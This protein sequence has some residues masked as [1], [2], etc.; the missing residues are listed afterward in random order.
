[1]ATAVHQ[2]IWTFTSNF[3]LFEKSQ[4]PNPFSIS[5]ENFKLLGSHFYVI[6]PSGVQES[7]V[8][9]TRNSIVR[10]IKAKVNIGNV[11]DLAHNRY[12]LATLKDTKS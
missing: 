8:I 3:K 5:N 2:S 6:Q 11:K 10:Y 12:Y 9:R 4:N 7:R 1:M